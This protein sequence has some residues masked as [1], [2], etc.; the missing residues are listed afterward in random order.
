MQ[1]IA[2]AMENTLNMSSAMGMSTLDEVHDSL[3]EIADSL[4]N[5]R[6]SAKEL[7]AAAQSIVGMAS[8]ADHLH[9]VVHTMKAQSSRDLKNIKEFQ[10]LQKLYHEQF[11]F[12]TQA[13]SA[14]LVVASI[15]IIAFFSYVFLMRV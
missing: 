12:Q 14:A 4:E 9:E 7:N 6:H 1:N 11:H 3:E 5:M 15:I 2:E 13:F 8:I 10:K